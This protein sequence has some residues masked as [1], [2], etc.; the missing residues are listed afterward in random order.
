[1][2]EARVMAATLVQA[3]PGL[4]IVAVVPAEGGPGFDFESIIELDGVAAYDELCEHVK[5]NPG[6]VRSFTIDGVT[7]SA[8]CREIRDG[9]GTELGTLVM[10]RQ[11]RVWS[12]R[13]KGLAKAFGGMLS[14]IATQTQREEHMLAQ[15][16]LDELVTR[17][18]KHLMSAEAKDRSKVLTWVVRQLAEFLGSD[19]ALLR[20]NDSPRGVSVMEAEWPEREWSGPGPDPLYEVA[21]D[22]EPVFAAMEHLK[23]PYFMGPEDATVEYMDLIEAGT[24]LVGVG[25]AAVPLLVG[26]ST[27]GVLAF[28]H[29]STHSWTAGEVRALEAVASML[30]QMQGR[31]DAEALTRYNANHDELTKLPNRRA[32]LAELDERLVDRRQTAIMVIDLDRFKIMN[33]FLGH[34]NGDKLLITM[35][36]RLTTSIRKG[37]FAAR[38]GGDEFVV[39][40]EAE[41][42]DIVGAGAQR[43]LEVLSES[44]EIGGQV[45]SH[46][47]SIGI[48]LSGETTNDALELLSQADI[49]M[50]AAKSRGRNQYVAFD[51]ELA[52]EEME[53]SRTELLLAEGIDD[54]GLELHYQPEVDLRTG[55][56]TAVEALVR[57]R[58][59]TKGLLAAGEF[60]T[61]A[62]Q[63]GLVT[64]IGRWVFNEACRQQ[65]AWAVLY[66]HLKLDMR[67]NMSPADFKFS[68]LVEFV[69]GCLEKHQV[70]PGRLCI[71]ITEHAMMRDADHTAAVLRRFQKLGVEVAIDDFGTGF[72]SMTEL[73][74][75]PVNYLKLDMSFVRG[76]LTDK[77]DRAIVKSICE[78]ASALDLGVIGEGI[79]DPRIA[80]ELLELGCHRGQGYLMS[81]PR[82][83]EDLRELLEAGGVPASL[84]SSGTLSTTT[85]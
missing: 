18:A 22:T 16:G 69:E 46:T 8:L 75:L 15:Q 50:Y 60:I 48:S 32:L 6:S 1:M 5:A 65:A 61:I 63:S 17:V 9:R 80:E 25:G 47:A 58:H 53:R 44:V 85:V 57:W 40:V 37:D 51:S 68:D 7:W 26:D 24:Q 79:E 56:V 71:E 42:D 36:D 59:P 74:H 78:L 4:S 52:G 35:S 13:E 19:V 76:I 12:T 45:V 34:A 31:F 81:K 14:L 20:R 27:W 84:L 66:P 55:V 43:I 30:V 54:G 33:D 41:G 83:A 62:E 28:L 38:L 67:V 64:A 82:S 77:Y 23:G 49:A 72:A 29:F 2:K 73:K 70:D 39:L 10:A 21:Y 3:I 11:G